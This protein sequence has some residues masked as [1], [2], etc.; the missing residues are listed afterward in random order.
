MIYLIL[1]L[2]VIFMYPAGQFLLTDRSARP[3]RPVWGATLS[4]PGIV[5]D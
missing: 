3:P 2:I 1:T 4:P 5:A